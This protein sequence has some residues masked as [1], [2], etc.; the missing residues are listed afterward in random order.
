VLAQSSSGSKPLVKD[1][2]KGIDTTVTGLL[3]VDGCS[4]LASPVA[5]SSEMS[6]FR[7]VKQRQDR[8]NAARSGIEPNTQSLTLSGVWRQRRSSVTSSTPP[9]GPT[10][11][12]P[13]SPSLPL[14]PPISPSQL[15]FPSNMTGSLVAFNG[16]GHPIMAGE[17][18]VPLSHV[19]PGPVWPSANQLKLAYTYG[20]R[21]ED[22]SYT[23]LIR[24]DELDSYDFER[25]PVSQGPEG[26]IVLPPLQRPR[27]EQ[28]E[29]P[30]IMV[31]NDV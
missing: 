21:R 17:E 8:M 19:T 28:R 22:G 13:P 29:G 26:M 11:L 2:S 25:V 14:R 1:V 20:I 15:Q 12:P 6:S 23:R 18:A 5:E 24:A 27:P 7:S 31:P 16:Q 30:E 4:I 10:M 3:T 9:T